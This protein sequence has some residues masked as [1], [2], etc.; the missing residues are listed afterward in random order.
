MSSW[1]FSTRYSVIGL[2]VSTV[3]SGQLSLTVSIP[4]SSAVRG[5]SKSGGRPKMLK[6][7]RHPA[8][9]I[10]K[11]SH[12]N[13]QKASSLN[14]LSVASEV[15]YNP[16]KQLGIKCISSLATTQT[17]MCLFRSVCYKWG[18]RGLN[19]VEYGT[20]WLP[21]RMQI[22]LSWPRNQ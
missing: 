1:R 15:L 4:V 22:L 20:L 14:S 18:K 11:Q 19:L 8:G 12:N 16:T 6:H 2:R 9:L 13:K 3:C 5:S 17:I 10:T 21:F 7:K